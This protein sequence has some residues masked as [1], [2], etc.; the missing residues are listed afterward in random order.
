MKPIRLLHTSDVHLGGGFRAPDHGDHHDHCLCPLVAL[1]RT[2]EAVDADAVLV[3]GDLFDNKRISDEFVSMVMSRLGSLGIPCAVICGNHDVHDETTLYRP[4]VYP[5]AEIDGVTYLDNPDG[6]IVELLDGALTVWGKAM[7]MHHPGFRPLASPPSRP[8]D[9]SWW[10]VLG[11]G[12]FEPVDAGPLARSSP[13]SPTEIE[14]TRA[15]YVALGHW[16]VRTDVSA[17]TV[18]AWYS[19]APY[20]VAASSTFN[21]VDLVPGQPASVAHVDVELAAAGCR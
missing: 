21:L 19:G 10:V 2:A 15:D 12:H 17:G 4:E 5:A 9:D 20:G 13:L 14:A 11:H 8:R 3:V 6:S 16:H 7:P 1:E 18:P